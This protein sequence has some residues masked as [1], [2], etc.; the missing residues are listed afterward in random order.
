LTPQQRTRISQ[1][2]LSGSNV[3]R[4]N[5]ANFALVTG[6]VVPAN[7]RFVAVPAALIEIN[8][9]WRGH[10]FFVVRDDIVI[11]DNS[12]RIVAVVPVGSSGGAQLRGGS[13]SSMAMDLSPAEIRQIQIVLEQKGFN[14][15]TIDGRLGP[16]TKE[17]LIAFQRQQGF[18]ATGVIDHQTVAAL[19]VSVRGMQGG[20]QGTTTGQGGMQQQPANQGSTGAPSGQTGAKPSTSGQG[21]QQ[22][23]A[24]QQAPTSGQRSQGGSQ[25]SNTTGQGG[26]QQPSANQNK[27]QNNMNTGTQQHSNPSSG[28]GNSTQQPK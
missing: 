24:N 5:N 7:V 18:Q 8:P 2:V 6:T 13:A 16:R 25:P 3:P 28:A 1:T 22:A 19:G 10:E 9:A 17:A 4:V 27:N 12:R 26:A 11:V 21:T 14:I 20:A 15:G 23:P